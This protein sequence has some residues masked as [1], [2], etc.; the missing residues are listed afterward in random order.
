[1]AAPSVSSR[2]QRP[3]PPL[4]APSRGYAA[5]TRSSVAFAEAI[6]PGSPVLPGAD[7]RTAAAAEEMVRSL[8]PALVPVWRFAHELLDKAAIGRTGK[9]FHKLSA[10]QQ[11][12]LLRSWEGDATLGPPLGLVSLLYKLVHFDRPVHRK[13]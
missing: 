2:P 3:P 8:H 5:S 6:V 1:M 11:E 10:A 13:G 9:A 12:Q 4:P 7:E